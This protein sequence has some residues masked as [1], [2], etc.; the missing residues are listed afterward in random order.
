LS[1]EN[2]YVES[3]PVNV[4]VTITNNSPATYRFKLADERIFSVDFDV[5]TVSNQPLES[6][7]ALI[8][9]RTQ[10]QHIFFR[11]IAVESGESFSFVEDLRDYVNLKQPG[12][13]VVRARVY[14][15]LYRPVSTNSLAV[16]STGGGAPSAAVLES[17]RLNLNLRP[18]VIPGPDGIPLQMDIATNAVLVREKLPPDQVV[19]YM[20]TARQKSQWE[21]FFLYLDL[22]AMLSRD[23]VRKRKWL[24][25]GEEGRRRMVEDYRQELRGSLIDGDIAV[26]PSEYVMERTQY[27]NFEG[28]VTV[29]EKFKSANFTE[30]RRYTYQLRQKDNIWTIVDYSVIKLGTE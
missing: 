7:D 20:L 6:A 30:L 22:E 9:K 23:A 11:E 13:F 1:E 8:R 27:N 25:E 12:S 3:S 17:N 2:P 16:V 21:K 14:P 24:A 5:R 19:D 29:L 15:E 28:T 26:I 10:Y 18:P 4:Q